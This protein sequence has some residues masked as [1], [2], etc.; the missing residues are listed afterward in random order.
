MD[1]SDLKHL[2]PFTLFAACALPI[3]CAADA[4]DPGSALSAGADGAHESVNEALTVPAW[5]GYWD[6]QPNDLDTVTNSARASGYMPISL[7]AW[8][9]PSAPRYAV[10]FVQRAGAAFKVLHGVGGSSFQA[11]FDAQAALN[12]KPTLLSFDGDT[13]NPVWGAVFSATTTGI[14]YTRFGL[15]SGSWTDTGTVEYWLQFAHTNNLIPSTLSIYGTAASPSY[16]LVLEPNSANVQWSVGQAFDANGYWNYKDN[17][18]SSDYQAFWNA[19]VP[20][21]NRVGIVDVNQNERY[22]AIYRED[23]VGPLVGRHGMTRADIDTQVAAQKAAGYFPISIQGGGDG[24]NARFAALFAQSDLPLAKQWTAA[25]STNAGDTAIATIDNAMRGFMDRNDVRQASLAVLDGKKLAYARGYSDQEPGLTLTN[26]TTTFRLASVGKIATAMEIMHLVDRGLIG[27]DDKVEDILHLKTYTG[28]APAS[29]FGTITVRNML[30][31]NFPTLA[32]NGAR[33]CLLR[34]TDVSQAAATTLGVSLPLTRPQAISLA[35]AS[36][37]LV[38]RDPSPNEG[39]YSNFGY[40]LLGQVVEAKRGTSLLSAMQTDLFA[41]L[42]ITHAHVAAS[43]LSAF[44]ANEAMYRTNQL[45]LSPNIDIAGSPLAETPYVNN[46]DVSE[47]AGGLSMA[48]LDMARLVSALGIGAG[49]PIYQKT[50]T[51]GTQVSTADQILNGLFGFDQSFNDSWGKRHYVKGGEITGTQTTVSFVN[52]GRTYVLLWARDNLDNLAPLDG[53]W[54]AWGTL[55]TA[56]HNATFTGR[57]DL[58]PSY[59][60]PSL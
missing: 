29:A 19:Q 50:T 37:A 4:Q 26:A 11:A 22:V 21:G 38:S 13:N 8:G 9:N 25:G 24:A 33:K 6:Y 15:T 36:S 16:A 34:D 48:A 56:I 47:A 44:Y 43:G 18:T 54:P 59:G 49:N 1:R 52:G 42:S 23:S 45:F 3:A 55:E 30:Q 32:V 41:P 35:L 5:L 28:A 40:E 17:L 51:S 20:A 12:Y 2:L 58:F 53:W 10:V 39:C 46:F 60:M 14:P 57:P 7:S 27:L 31:H